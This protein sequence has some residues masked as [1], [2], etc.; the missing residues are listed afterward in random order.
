MK[1][2]FERNP[3]K[4]KGKEERKKESLKAYTNPSMDQTWLP[5]RDTCAVS[6]RF[7]I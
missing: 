6:H 7:C 2:D 4:E 1:K 5:N 3:R